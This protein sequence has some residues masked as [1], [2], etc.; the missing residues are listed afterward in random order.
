MKISKGLPYPL[1]ATIQK[2]GVNFSLFAPFATKVYLLLFDN[3]IDIFPTQIEII[4]RSYHYWHIFVED[5]QENQLYAYRVDGEYTPEKG[6]RFD[7]SKVLTDPYSKALVTQ[8]YSRAL[9]STF[10]RD[11]VQSCMKSVVITDDFD[12]E[13]VQK[14]DFQLNESIIYELHV[15]GFTQSETS[16][17]THKGTFS[18]I[19][20]KLPYLKS[21]GIN[22]I[23]LLPIFAFDKYDAPQGKENYWGYSPINF[24]SLHNEYLSASTPQ[25]KIIEFKNFVKILHQNHF[26]I[27]LDV[28]Y[29]H[30]TEND[31][32]APT[33][34]FRG[35]SN[36][37]YY[38]LDEKGNN[39]NFSG[40]GNTINANHSVVR[41]MILDSLLYWTEVMQI[42]GFRFDLA[43]I[44]SRDEDGNPM[45]NPP[46]LWGIDSHPQLTNTILIAE[47]WDAHGLNQSK[48]FAG[49][50]WGIWNGDYRDIVR[51]F[52]KGDLGC[53]Q[54]FV[55]HFTGSE[56]KT[57]GRHFDF[58]PKRNIQFITAHDGFTLKDL[59][60]YNQKHNQDNG[61]NGNDGSND[62]FSWNCGE[63]GETSNQNIQQLRER[64]LKNL[65][66][67]LIFSHG[68]PMIL[69]GDEMQRTQYGN[70]NAYCQNNEISWM[71]WN[72]E[73][74]HTLYLQFVKNLIALQK[75]YE[76]FR[77]EKFYKTKPNADKPY[78]VFH[79]TTLHAPD[80][81]YHSQSIAFEIIY[82]AKKEHLLFVINMFWQE[83]TFQLP[84]GKWKRLS[85]TN[86]HT[87]NN[88]IF[89]KEYKAFGRS[90]IIFEKA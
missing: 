82:T 68:V 79:G 50:K 1:G 34:N 57:K 10:G 4:N 17:I 78:L 67:I 70:N 11:N 41:R 51:K 49:D 45:K 32:D 58:L 81:S 72:L 61:E 85:D 7:V 80:W 20:E 64:Q 87:H 28:V 55:Y 8:N 23:E 77:Y 89:S 83:L 14:P 65:L 53:L 73:K 9:A 71:D 88:E 56:G 60:S 40:C 48:N 15:G 44:L 35:I 26:K 37:S 63:E 16:N 25:Q 30:S 5:I 74:E 76:I 31:Y 86:L 29:N 22:T 3:E 39:K 18:G 24:F 47:P 69:M 42:D 59:V 62:N 52:V 36:S 38:I 66:S 90:V 2:N 21:L 75:K 33:Y 27:I 46:L 13:N 12:W 84:K 43:S 54:D 6:L 19:I